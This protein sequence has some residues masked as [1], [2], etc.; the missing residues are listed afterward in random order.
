MK[1]P[2]ETPAAPKGRNRYSGLGLAPSPR[3]SPGGSLFGASLHDCGQIRMAPLAGAVGLG[4]PQSLGCEFVV[5]R[6]VGAR[7]QRRI[8][9][10]EA[11]RPSETR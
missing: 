7:D 6:G 4:H 8:L 3:E 9:A 5:G 1:S 2:A 10:Q 11:P